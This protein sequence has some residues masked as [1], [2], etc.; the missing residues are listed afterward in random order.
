MSQNTPSEPSSERLPGGSADVGN[1][2][3]QLRGFWPELQML[4]NATQIKDFE[5][6][7]SP[8][9][10]KNNIFSDS[11]II[12]TNKNNYFKNCILENDVFITI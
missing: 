5:R 1:A 4:K 3:S 7:W 9:A 6:C 8:E 12:C 10:N 11:T 2:Q